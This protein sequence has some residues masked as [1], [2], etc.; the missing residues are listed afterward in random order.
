MNSDFPPQ[1][2]PNTANDSL[3]DF[4][5]QIDEIV[6]KGSLLA[7]FAVLFTRD[8]MAVLTEG[9]EVLMVGAAEVVFTDIKN[10]I[11]ARM[12]GSAVAPVA[13][14]SIIRPS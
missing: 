1:G 2:I 12:K 9:D 7:A 4:Q 10:A 3:R 8:G 5:K 14:P 13:R 11:A 6:A